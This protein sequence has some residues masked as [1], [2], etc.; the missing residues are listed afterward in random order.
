MRDGCVWVV[1]V[2]DGAQAGQFFPQ[3]E[4]CQLHLIDRVDV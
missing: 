2:G 3:W 4:T 1:G